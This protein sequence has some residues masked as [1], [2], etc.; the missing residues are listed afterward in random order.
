MNLLTED[1]R[2][3]WAALWVAYTA[4][5][6]IDQP[7]NAIDLL[8]NGLAPLLRDGL[9]TLPLAEVAAQPFFSVPSKPFE[10]LIAET[11]MWLVDHRPGLAVEV[12]AA[13]QRGPVHWSKPATKKPNTGD[14]RLFRQEKSP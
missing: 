1:L 2:Q 9:L 13:F 6:L 4:I 8:T 12:S 11:L 3:R 5:R 7:C 10:P 14:P